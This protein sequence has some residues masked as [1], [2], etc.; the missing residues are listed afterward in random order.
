MQHFCLNIGLSMWCFEHLFFVGEIIKYCY[1]MN[2][3]VEMC[4]IMA[5]AC[6]FLTAINT[7]D[8]KTSNLQNTSLT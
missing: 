2:N 5:F 7:T 4:A 3:L 6:D 1:V 8:K